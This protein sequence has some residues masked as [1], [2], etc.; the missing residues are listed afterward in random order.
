MKKL[1]YVL[2]VMVAFVACSDSG[3]DDGGG[4]SN[5]EK[6]KVPEIT[7]D[8]TA[9]NFATDGGSTIVIFTS[10][11]AWT[12]EAINNR[13]DAWCSVSPTSGSAGA[14]KITITTTAND[15]TDDRTATIVIK[16]GTAQK[17]IAVSQKQKDALTVTSSKFE[18]SADGED[19][20]I[21]VKANIDFNVEIEESAKSWVTHRSTR[22][23][24]SS[25][26]IIEVD[27]NDGSE[28]RKA[29]ISITGGGLKE[30]ITIYQE[31]NKP[32][33]VISQNE[34]VVSSNGETIAVDVAS[35]VNV[36]VE[37]P[38]EIDWI[39]E[40]TPR[41]MSTNTYRFDIEQNEDYDQR[42]AEIR[43]TNKENNLTEV[44]KVVQVQKDALVVAKD[45]YILKSDGGQIPIEVGYNIDFDIEISAD[46]ITKV[47]TRTFV[48]ETLIFDVAKNTNYESREGTIIFKSKDGIISQAVKIHQTQKDVIVLAKDSYSLGYIEENIEIKVGHNVDFNIEISDNWITKVDTRKYTTDTLIFNIAENTSGIE[49]EGS[50]IFTSI[51]GTVKQIVKVCQKK[52]GAIVEWIDQRLQDEYYW[53]DEYKAKLNTFD[54]SLDYDKFLST[55]LLSMT[56]NMEDGYVSGGTRY[57]Y[58]YIT[59]E[60]TTRAADNRMENSFGI[61]IA[62]RYFGGSNNTAILVV[63]HVYPNSPAANAGLKRGDTITK[64]DNATIPSP[65]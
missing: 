43:F 45:S 26:L 30:T 8:A 3:I 13:A 41:A 23:M 11:D 36:T 5:N 61:L 12:A 63:E 20:E 51:D 6:P 59:R 62:G 46:W 31:S 32:S 24:K 9:A 55:S 2:F 1:L 56:T 33:I 10:S 60:S 34:Y 53:L 25:T 38:T 52:S 21:E 18:V 17:S 15:T 49:R 54:Y 50:I 39:S 47:D 42:S 27:E 64:V 29:N 19:I 28:K 57:L 37:L 22:A 16:S 40:N 7:L 48:T 44:V 65:S 35:N 4:N 14:S 58:S